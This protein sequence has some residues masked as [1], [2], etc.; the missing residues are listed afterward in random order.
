MKPLQAKVPST[1]GAPRGMRLTAITVEATCDWARAI[2]EGDNPVFVAPPDGHL[3]EAPST[4]Q[5]KVLLERH[6]HC[7]EIGIWR[8]VKARDT[9]TIRGY[10]ASDQPFL[11]ITLGHGDNG[12]I[13]VSSPSDTVLNARNSGDGQNYLSCRLAL[14]E[15][16]KKQMEAELAAEKQ[17]TA[18]VCADAV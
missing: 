14:T 2:I 15:D 16:A 10:V 3:Q 8:S 12:W 6:D 4:R 18:A 9:V 5:G 13:R 7:A 1:A 11:L 17:Q